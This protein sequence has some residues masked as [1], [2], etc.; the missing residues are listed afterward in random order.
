MLQV[1]EL[2]LLLGRGRAAEIEDFGAEL[3]ASRSK[4]VNL[5]LD[6]AFPD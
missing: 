3:R 6:I 5:I 1:G 4:Q 2:G